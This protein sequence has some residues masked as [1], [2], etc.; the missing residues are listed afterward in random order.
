MGV[1]LIG[2]YLIGVYLMGVYLMGVYLIGVHP[3]GVHLMDVV[4]D[5]FNLGFWEKVPIPHCTH[6]SICSCD[7]DLVTLAAPQPQ[8]TEMFPAFQVLRDVGCK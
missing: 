5:T 1:Y 4:W 6:S 8:S 7:R 3:L 2:V